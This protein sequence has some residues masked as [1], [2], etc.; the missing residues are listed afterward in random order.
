MGKK[1]GDRDF[2]LRTRRLELPLSEI[3][4]EQNWKALP[5]LRFGQV[6]ELSNSPHVGK[7]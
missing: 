7:D 1:E 6:F 5:E 2:N 4:V 3:R